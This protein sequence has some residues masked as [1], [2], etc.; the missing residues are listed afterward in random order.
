MWLFAGGGLAQNNGSVS[1]Q[2]ERRRSRRLVLPVGHLEE[3]SVAHHVAVGVGQ[4]CRAGSICSLT[5]RPGP[6][7]APTRRRAPS[8][9]TLL[10]EVHG[11]GRHRRASALADTAPV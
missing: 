10:E 8:A 2:G 5:Q 4:S 7:P 3:G 9:R 6:S 1:L 11:G